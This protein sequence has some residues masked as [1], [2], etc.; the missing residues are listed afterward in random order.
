MFVKTTNNYFW[1]DLVP[2]SVIRAHLRYEE[3]EAEY[4]INEYAAN[5]IDYM[6]EV[7]G[8]SFMS[9]DATAL[10]EANVGVA[11]LAE[12]GTAVKSEK[13][14]SFTK[15]EVLS[16][17][18]FRV[19]GLTGDWRLYTT[20]DLI[21]GDSCFQY[22]YD[23]A[24]TEGNTVA[25]WDAGFGIRIQ[26]HADAW[27]FNFKDFDSDFITG[28][29]RDDFLENRALTIKLEGGIELTTA[30]RAYRQAM[31]LLVGHYDTQREAEYVG[32]ITSEIK[33]GVQR[34][35]QSQMSY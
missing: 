22:W 5:A 19:G 34:L 16:G 14:I 2:K 13:L 32:G 27:Y 8:V 18:T 30:P 24:G 11:S 9:N 29:L 35:L 33:E 3:N 20:D 15:D 26:Q 12:R 25:A 1:E 7:T 28:E 17:E 21:T 6:M 23:D 31:L 4:A 10:N